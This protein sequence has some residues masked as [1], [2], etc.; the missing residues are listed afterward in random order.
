MLTTVGKTANG[1]MI[2]LVVLF[3]INGIRGTFA[4]RRIRASQQTS[5]EEEV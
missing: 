5:V 2:A 1:A 3:F 4:Y